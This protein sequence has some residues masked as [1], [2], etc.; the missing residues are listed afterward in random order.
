MSAVDHPE[1]VVKGNDSFEDEKYFYGIGSASGFNNYSLRRVAADNRARND[2][3][4][5]LK[6]YTLSL[7]KDYE[8]SIAEES[9][10]NIERLTENAIRTVTEY[11]LVGVVIID[12]WEHPNRNELFSLARI[13]KAAVAERV[14]ENAEKL[15]KE[16]L[17][18]RKE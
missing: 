9:R 14:R 15:H 17:R 18:E 1:W 6:V 5:Y 3:A 13:D 12:H 10:V 16:L 2:I 8:A 4:K 7:M 11:T